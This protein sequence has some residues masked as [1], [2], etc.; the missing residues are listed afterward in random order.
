VAERRLGTPSAEECSA[1]NSTT[2]A[3]STGQS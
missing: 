3:S 2:F 1:Y